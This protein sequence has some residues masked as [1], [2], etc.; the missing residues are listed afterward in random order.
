[1]LFPRPR[2]RRW[3]VLKPLAALTTLALSAGILGV[4][5]PAFAGGAPGGL[6]TQV[7]ASV[8]GDFDAGVPQL[9]TICRPVGAEAADFSLWRASR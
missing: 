5:T 6:A 1:M 9:V 7:V 4:A 2:T 3:A 8:P